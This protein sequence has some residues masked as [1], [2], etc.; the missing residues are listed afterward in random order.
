MFV[1]SAA[2]KWKM[3][4]RIL[5]VAVLDLSKWRSSGDVIL[6]TWEDHWEDHRTIIEHLHLRVLLLHALYVCV[7]TS[8]QIY[9]TCICVDII[10]FVSLN[11]GQEWFMC[12]FMHVY[13]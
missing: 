4:Y 13:V 1:L 8:A 12:L 2:T 7:Y 6:T 9:Y 5:F 3:S 11:G 10:L